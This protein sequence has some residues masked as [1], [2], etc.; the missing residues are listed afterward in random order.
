MTERARPTSRGRG[1]GNAIGGFVA[2]LYSVPEGIGYAALAG[3][4]PMLGIYA[5]MVPVAVAAAFKGSVLMMST[6]TSAIALTMGGILDEAA[7]TAAQVPQAV[8]TLALLAGLI[9]AAL[10]ALKLGTIVSFVSNAVMPGSSWA[11][12]SLSWWARPATSSATTRTS[13]TRS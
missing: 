2:G 10:G 1:I 8:F 11:R 3:I 9:M 12:P 4:G 5:G 6:L 7:F 13:A